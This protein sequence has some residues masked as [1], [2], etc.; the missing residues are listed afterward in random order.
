MTSPSP[1]AVQVVLVE[2]QELFRQGLRTMLTGAGLEVTAEYSSAAAVLPE[3]GGAQD[4][5]P[6]TVVFCSLTMPGW[7]ELIG[8]LLM[9]L[10]DCPILGVVDAVTEKVAIEALSHGV[11]DCLDRT[12]PL[13]QWVSSV[14]EVRAGQI[15]PVQTMVRYP[16]VARQALMLLSQPPEPAGLQALAPVLSYRERLVL[17]NLSEGVALEAI[18]DRM[19]ASEEDVREILKSVCR[20]LVARHRLVG[21]WDQVR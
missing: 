9:R 18:G 20:K 5:E 21:I 1:K 13:D 2:E 7:Q 16:G 17:G 4:L 3:E 6:G 8:R 14:L 15:S 19:G 10:P 12:L 11:L